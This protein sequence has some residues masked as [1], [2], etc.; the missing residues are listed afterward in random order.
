MY[1]VSGQHEVRSL[2]KRSNPLTGD[3]N[4]LRGVETT[5]IEPATPALQRLCSPN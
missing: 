3:F 2:T 4:G 1:L 5:G